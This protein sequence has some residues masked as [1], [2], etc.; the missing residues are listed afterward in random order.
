M[1]VLN[2]ILFWAGIVLLTDG[3]LGLF[4]QEK[5]QKLV[6]GVNILRIA[7][8]EIGLGLAL[9]AAHYVLV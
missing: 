6:A 2:S 5:W 9:L 3:S 7:A 1:N 8:V 4:F